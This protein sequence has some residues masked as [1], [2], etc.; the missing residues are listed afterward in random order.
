MILNESEQ[1]VAELTQR[2]LDLETRVAR[3]ES[4]L[5][6]GQAKEVRAGKPVSINE[7]VRTKRPHSSVE[8]AV[9]IG[10]FLERYNKLESFTQDDLRQGFR[11]AKETMPGNL[12][13]TINKCIHKSHFTET[14]EKRDGLRLLAVTNSGT[15]FV[16]NLPRGSPS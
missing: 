6:S 2:L 4:S 12:A 8:T 13:E 5:T 11:N 7:W 3:I 9:V 14:G 16:D 15:E 1:S 10:V